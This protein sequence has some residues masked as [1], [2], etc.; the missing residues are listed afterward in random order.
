MCEACLE[1]L[2]SVPCLFPVLTHAPHHSTPTLKITQAAPGSPR[3]L[4]L[5]LDARLASPQPGPCKCSA[6]PAPTTP[7]NIYIYTSIYLS[8]QHAVN[9]T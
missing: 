6:S 5:L 4:F 1:L 2:E 9:S 3:Q 7:V 8:T